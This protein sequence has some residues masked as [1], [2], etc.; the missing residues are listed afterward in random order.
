MI[1]GYQGHKTDKI[2]KIKFEIKLVLKVSRYQKLSQGFAKF[3][4]FKAQA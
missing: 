2:S 1:Q 3:Y 4:Q